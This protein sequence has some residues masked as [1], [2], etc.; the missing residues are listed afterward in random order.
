MDLQDE[1]QHSTISCRPPSPLLIY[2]IYYYRFK[3]Q[4]IILDKNYLEHR[5]DHS[6]Y[7]WVKGKNHIPSYNNA[8]NVAQTKI[9]LTKYHELQI[10]LPIFQV[11]FNPCSLVHHT[12]S[13]LYI[14]HQRACDQVTMRTA[15]LPYPRKGHNVEF[16]QGKIQ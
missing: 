16:L 1:T 3:I 14:Y 15:W 9:I 11:H 12:G 13:W 2:I 5:S 7:F 6:V 8:N 10:D 4:Y